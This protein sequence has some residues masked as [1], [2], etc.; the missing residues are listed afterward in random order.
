MK[1]I[2]VIPA[3]Y[4][5]S[6]Y[7]G[8][9][10][11]NILGKPM[12][13]HVAEKAAAALGIGNTYIATE[14]QR[15]IDCAQQYGYKAVMTADTHLTGTDR[16]WE[17]SQKIEADIYINIQG[18]EPML[19]PDDIAM[20][21]NKRVQ[22]PE[23]IINGMAPLSPG[24]DVTSVNIPKVLTD[25]NCNLIYMSRLAIPGIKGVSDRVPAYRKQVC[26]Y[27]FT[28]AELAAFG[29]YGKKTPAES[30][31]DIEI[32][33]FLEMGYKIKMVETSK[34]SLAVDIP[35]DVA[36]VEEAMKQ[37]LWQ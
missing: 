1:V 14:D 32:L 15:I 11:V 27:A 31:E 3:R 34:N 7:P 30:F 33:R 21:A 17:V 37:T 10:L 9:P 13:I 16:L 8:K 36:R 24:D 29:E 4:K 25:L 26:I 5:S 12:I 35:E 18:D 23:Y 19:N 20:I 28:A 2:G 6:R 22:F